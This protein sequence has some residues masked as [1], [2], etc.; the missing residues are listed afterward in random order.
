MGKLNLDTTVRRIFKSYE[1]NREDW[2]RPHLGASI[3]GK[4]CERSVWY[5]F[6]WAQDPGF[7]GR[8]LRL[9]NTGEREEERLT[10]DLINAGVIVHEADQSTGQQFKVIGL[11]GHLGGSMDGAGKGFVEAPDSW[12]VLEY[13]TSSDY[14]FK[15]LEK[16]GCF[17][18]KP[19]HYYQM[20]IYMGG[21]GLKRAAYLVRNKNTDDLYLEFIKFNAGEYSKIMNRAKRIIQAENPPERAGEFISKIPCKWCN[22][23][24][25]CLGYKK[26]APVMRLP[27][28]NCRTC[29]HSEPILFDPDQKPT[30][31]MRKDEDHEGVWACHAKGGNLDEDQQRSGCELHLFHPHLLEPLTTLDGEWADHHV[32]GVQMSVSYK[33]KSESTFNLINHIDTDRGRAR[34]KTIGSRVELEGGLSEDEA[35]T[36]MGDWIVGSS[37]EL[38]GKIIDL[39]GDYPTIKI[40]DDQ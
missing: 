28:F 17:S 20:M 5:A 7:P 37:K 36:I 32:N 38:A 19:E 1:V 15:K 26:K 8:I 22:Y 35:N 11:D 39:S 6:R 4:E 13:K 31:S 21:A 27:E 2:R 24:E 10:S 34:L 3:V 9:F 29:A 30:V 23:N 16:E 12:H 18:A 33:H 25:M 40:K 14:A